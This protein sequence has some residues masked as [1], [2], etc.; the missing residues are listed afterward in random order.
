[1]K[2]DI[3]VLAAHPDDAE[4]SCSGTILAHIANGKKVGLVDL[5]RGELGT[6]GSAELR[7]K[8]A[9]ASAKILGLTVRENLKFKDFFFKNDYEHQLRVVELIRKYRPEIV[10]ANAVNDRHP[11]HGKAAELA[12]VACFMAGLRKIESES[13]GELQEAWRPKAVYHYIQSNYI[14]PDFVFDVSDYWDKKVQSIMAFKSQF[15]DPNSEEPETFI[16]SPDFLKLIEGRAKDFGHSIGVS[17][18][19]GF[20]Q[21]RYL[22]VKDLFD[23]I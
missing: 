18:G 16:S 19:E 8:E 5:T 12:K 6:R 1:M 21:E 13:D 4:L 23:L 20:T 10:L 11:D 9:A 7:D 14:K 3:L 15:H 17:Y 22:G 2:L